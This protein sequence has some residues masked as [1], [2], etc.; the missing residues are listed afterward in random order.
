MKTENPNTNNHHENCTGNGFNTNRCAIHKRWCAK[1][2]VMEQS[3]D[4]DIDRH[5]RSLVDLVLKGTKKRV[6]DR[7][8]VCEGAR[9]RCLDVAMVLLCTNIYEPTA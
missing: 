8:S 9:E 5:S 6:R 7:E 3:S 1:P 2:L 4:I